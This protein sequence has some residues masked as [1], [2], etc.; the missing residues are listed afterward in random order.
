MVYSRSR[1]RAIHP[2]AGGHDEMRCPRDGLGWKRVKR[3]HRL[4]NTPEVFRSATTLAETSDDGAL[5]TL[6]RAGATPRTGSS[7]PKDEGL[8]QPP[9]QKQKKQIVSYVIYT[10]AQSH[11]VDLC[12]GFS[13]R[14]RIH[15]SFNMSATDIPR[16]SYGDVIS[17]SVFHK[18]RLQGGVSVKIKQISVAIEDFVGKLYEIT[19]A[20]GDAG[21][22]I[23]ALNLVKTVDFGT[24]RLIVSDVA[25]SQRILKEMN[26]LVHMDEVVAVELADTPGSLADFL[27]MIKEAEISVAYMYAVIGSVSGKAIM[28]FRFINND[29]AIELLKK[30]GVNMLTSN[31]LRIYEPVG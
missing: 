4:I 17:N 6:F 31:D 19:R 15:F 27:K 7:R 8:L 13:T 16:P 18:T 23:R 10:N 3:Y 2:A 20:L 24:V 11:C 25:T 29:T 30:K 22:N 1:C 5:A 26:M 21:V 12:L 14:Q 9:A 28:I